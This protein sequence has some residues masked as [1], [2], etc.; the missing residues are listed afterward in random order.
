MTKSE[1]RRTPF[2]WPKIA[3]EVTAAVGTPTLATAGKDGTPRAVT[4]GGE[5]KDSLFEWRS[6]PS[7]VHSKQVAENPR[8]A[9]DFFDPKTNRVVYGVAQVEKTEKE[10]DYLRYF[11]R[12]MELWVVIDEEVD[13]KYVEPQQINPKD[14]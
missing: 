2:D 13:G 3:R 4:V 11:A 10:D 7:R 9:F 6:W 8:I 14:L 5:L 12:V 1:S